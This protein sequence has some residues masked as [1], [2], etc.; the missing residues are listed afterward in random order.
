MVE[1]FFIYRKVIMPRKP[2][3]EVRADT[4]IARINQCRLE[5]A[6]EFV[7]KIFKEKEYRDGVLIVFVGS[8]VDRIIIPPN[9]PFQ[10]IYMGDRYSLTKHLIIGLRSQNVQ[11][12]AHREIPEITAYTCRIPIESQTIYITYSGAP[13]ST[14][15]FIAQMISSRLFP[16]HYKEGFE[17]LR[18]EGSISQAFKG[19]VRRG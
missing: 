4:I 2:R 14:C 16:K 11:D 7:L 15:V 5:K 13:Q 3:N 17:H 1:K 9:N 6:I 10:T 8:S 19:V 18:R 12:V